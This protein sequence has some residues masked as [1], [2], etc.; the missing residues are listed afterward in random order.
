MGH[1]CEAKPC[2]GMP[3]SQADSCPTMH[4]QIESQSVASESEGE[5]EAPRASRRRRRRRARR[6]KT[7]VASG[8]EMCEQERISTNVSTQP[9]LL[10][11]QAAVTVF[12]LGLLPHAQPSRRS[13]DKG[14]HPQS[15]NGENAFPIRQVPRPMLLEN[16]LELPPLPFPLGN[17]YSGHEVAKEGTPDESNCSRSPS[18]LW[19]STPQTPPRLCPQTSHDEKYC[20]RTQAELW[21]ATPLEER[22]CPQTP[23]EL[24]PA[25][26]M[27]WPAIN[28]GMRMSLFAQDASRHESIPTSWEE[29][30]VALAPPPSLA[31][32]LLTNRCGFDSAPRLDGP[33]SATERE[34]H[35]RAAVVD[36]QI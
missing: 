19:P 17:V 28:P 10:H 4:D 32:N 18:T 13:T 22:Q 1:E 5:V 6:S 2:P 35:L 9:R 31:G 27:A 25:T 7:T 26:P 30:T 33:T 11:E 8:E 16:F 36:L 15:T 24:W 20:L 29:V 3:D 12:D 23:S 21:T 14:L 34:R